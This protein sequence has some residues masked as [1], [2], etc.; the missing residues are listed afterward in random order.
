VIFNLSYGL[1]STDPKDYLIYS[2]ENEENMKKMIEEN[3]VTLNSFK[4]IEQSW[5]YV[6]VEEYF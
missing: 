3:V 2:T 6:N 5:Y 1:V 4:V